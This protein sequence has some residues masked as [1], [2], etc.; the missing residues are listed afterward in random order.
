MMLV[1]QM[2]ASTAVLGPLLGRF[3]RVELGIP[4]GDDFGGRPIDIHLS[5]LEML[6]AR[7]ETSA[8]GVHDE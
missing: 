3:G 8:D 5:G 2:R 7:F 4:G 1:E 6:G